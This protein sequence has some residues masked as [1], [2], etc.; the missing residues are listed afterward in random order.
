MSKAQYMRHRRKVIKGVRD[1]ILAIDSDDDSSAVAAEPI[2]MTVTHCTDVDESAHCQC[3]GIVETSDFEMEYE[4]ALLSDSDES[5]AGT[6]LSAYETQ[7]GTDSCSST[8]VAAEESTLRCDLAAWA[9]SS[10]ATFKDITNL[11]K[12][13]QK[14]GVSSLPSDARTLV[15]TPR[16]VNV[17]EKCGGQY[18]YFGL[19]NKI[20]LYC[21]RN[22]VMSV[23]LIINIDGLPLFKSSNVQFWPILCTIVSNDRASMEPFLVALYCGIS[24]PISAGEY[25]EDFL[26]ELS[27]VMTNGVSDGSKK[28][29]V[30]LKAFVC[31][32][33]ARAWLKR[34]KLHSGYNSCERCTAHGSYESGRV[35][36]TDLSSPL[37]TDALFLQ[38]S[39]KGHQEGVSPLSVLL[40]HFG[41]VS[42]FVL[43]YMHLMCLGVM[44]RLLYFWSKGPKKFGRLSNSLI[45]LISDDA[46]SLRPLIPSD[47]AR[48]PRSL[49]EL[50]R[51]KATEFRMFLL[52]IGPVILKQY[53]EKSKF[54]NFLCFSVAASILLSETRVE[55]IEYARKLLVCFVQQS[56]KLYG[57]TFVVYNV[58][59]LIHVAD[60]VLFHGCTLNKISCFPFENY[61]QKLK[62]IDKL[63]K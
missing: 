6:V 15:Q 26:N 16:N 19:S 48:K 56:E 7:S 29:D 49:S 53:L 25:L 58:H 45:S 22:S 3:T 12:L 35:T 50:D 27:L 31:D 9:C 4:K 55:M 5:E 43:D 41:A 46:V 1:F 28:F 60:D 42:G 11:L 44:R 37:R 18:C 13:L 40:P 30:A 10:S 32:A 34:I 57:S 54:E 20:Q 61:L 63:F 14:Y 17:L 47:F 36:M 23:Q 62:K 39:Y 8:E 51:W 59:S 2:V 21:N 24:K 52:Y 38:N 33:P